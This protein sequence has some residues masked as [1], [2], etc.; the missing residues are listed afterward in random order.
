M[1]YKVKI[2]NH[3]WELLTVKSTNIKANIEEEIERV[4]RGFISTIKDPRLKLEVVKNMMSRLKQITIVRNELP[5]FKEFINTYPA[6]HPPPKEEKK[7][8]DKKDEEKA[9]KM[10]EEKKE[11]PIEVEPKP[12]EP[13]EDLTGI[14]QLLKEAVAYLKSEEIYSLLFK[15]LSQ[16]KSIPQ[17][18]SILEFYQYLFDS[19]AED[20]SGI[21]ADIYRQLGPSHTFLIWCKHFTWRAVNFFVE[22]FS[23]TERMERFENITQQ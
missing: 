22:M 5:L 23:S 2:M 4:F 6:K 11:E 14:P 19:D 7:E 18:E 17:T 12:V 16:A 8:E 15:L 1:E 9:E 3:L 21:L 13:A 20:I 10:D